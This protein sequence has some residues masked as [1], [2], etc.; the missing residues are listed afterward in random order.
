MLRFC[1]IMDRKEEKKVPD[2]KWKNKFVYIA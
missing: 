2:S 1:E